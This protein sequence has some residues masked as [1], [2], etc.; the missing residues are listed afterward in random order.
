M[1]IQKIG[2]NTNKIRNAGNNMTL[3][4]AALGLI[5]LN[6]RYIGCPQTHLRKLSGVPFLSTKG[7]SLFPASLDS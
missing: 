1:F 7:A 2:I 5:C 4:Y 6:F 3:R